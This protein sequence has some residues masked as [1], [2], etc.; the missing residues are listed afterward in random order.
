M[1]KMLSAAAFAASALAFAAAPGIAA[2]LR[3][4]PSKAYVPGNQELFAQGVKAFDAHDYAKAYAI[5]SELA[6]HDDLAAIRNV[7]LMERKG[8]GTPR[9]P[10]AALKHYEAAARGG[11]PTAAADLGQ[12]L[13]YG[14]AGDADPKAALPWL[15]LAARSG[16][17]MAQFLLGQM[18]EL[19]EAVPQDYARAELL[20]AAAAAH[21]LKPAIYRLSYLKGWAAP[22]FDKKPAPAAK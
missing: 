18:Y 8:L 15:K 5:F 17:P 2:P 4:S 20:Y 22:K 14:E 10:Q 9:N 1:L 7:A 12:M 13:L 21:G 11:L 3:E 16:H 19:G 6:E